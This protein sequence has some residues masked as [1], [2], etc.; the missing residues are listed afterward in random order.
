MRAAGDGERASPRL[1]RPVGGMQ[2]VWHPM[3]AGSAQGAPQ[4]EQR[5]LWRCGA[6]IARYA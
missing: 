4:G 6:G 5:G 1:W 3:D 2:R